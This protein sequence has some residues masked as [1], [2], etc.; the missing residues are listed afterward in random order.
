LTTG[1]LRRNKIREDTRA[2]RE[3]FRRSRG[4]PEAALCATILLIGQPSVHGRLKV[5]VEEVML[6]RW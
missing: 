5:I 2:V 4:D 3:A 1:A 6:G